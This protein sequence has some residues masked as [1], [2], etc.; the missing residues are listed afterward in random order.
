MLSHVDIK[1]HIFMHKMH[2][3]FQKDP[4]EMVV[5]SGKCYWKLWL[6]ERI[7]KFLFYTLQYCLNIFTKCTYNFK[8]KKMFSQC[9]VLKSH[10][11]TYFFTRVL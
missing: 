9:E 1:L 5:F 10:V 11:W 6:E 3:H 7:F 4:K 2:K 8:N